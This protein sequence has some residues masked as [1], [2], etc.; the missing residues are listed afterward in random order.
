M[1]F[2]GER[3]N[4]LQP[5]IYKFILEKNKTPIQDLARK[6]AEAGAAYID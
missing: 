1:I 2:I 6:Q 5:R 4:G 3:I